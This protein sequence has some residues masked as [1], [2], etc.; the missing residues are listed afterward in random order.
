[1]AKMSLEK[2][3]KAATSARNQSSVLTITKGNTPEPEPAPKDETQ[4]TNQSTNNENVQIE[5]K[6]KNINLRL[7]LESWKQ[8]RIAATEESTSKRSVTVTGLINQIIDDYLEK[9]G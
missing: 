7:P 4:D 9:R 6:Y 3:T 2:A 1:M 8:L 5:D